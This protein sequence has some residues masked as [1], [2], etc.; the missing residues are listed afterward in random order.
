VETL[1]TVLT[2]LIAEGVALADVV[3]LSPVRF[4]RS[5]AAQLAHDPTYPVIPLASKSGRPPRRG[6]PVVFSTVHAFKGMES[7]V[8]ILMDVDRMTGEGPQA[9]LYVAMSRARS[10]LIVLLHERLRPVLQA[11]VQRRLVRGWSA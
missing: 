6:E 9:L 11:A 8:V 4:E 10:H 2:L 3:I 5:A 1:R 7:P